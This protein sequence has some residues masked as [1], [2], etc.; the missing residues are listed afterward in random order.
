MLDLFCRYLVT[1]GKV[2]ARD[3]IEVDGWSSDWS[4]RGQPA[5]KYVITN[6][7]MIL[8]GHSLSPYV[9]NRQ[10]KGKNRFGINLSKARNGMEEKM[11]ISQSTYMRAGLLWHGF[12][13]NRREVT[14][15]H[16][17]GQP[18]PHQAFHL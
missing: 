1:L 14:K 4:W 13:G 17:L 2:L 5:T 12:N 15:E 11:E 8:V 6:L 18:G 3:R 16:G 7:T 10:L 9:Y